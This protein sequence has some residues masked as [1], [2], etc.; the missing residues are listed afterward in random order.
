MTCKASR[1][2]YFARTEIEGALS[3]VSSYKDTNPVG[4]GPHPLQLHLTLIISLEVSSPNIAVLE[5]GASY[6]LC[7]D[8]NI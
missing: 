7:K 6:E 4:S 2:K 5:V 3:C 8:T 1:R